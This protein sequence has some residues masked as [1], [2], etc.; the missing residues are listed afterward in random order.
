MNTDIPSVERTTLSTEISIARKKI[1]E[2]KTIVLGGDESSPNK[3]KGRNQI[4]SLIQDVNDINDNLQQI[5][6][7]LH[8]LK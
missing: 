3:E 2:I 8:G 7:A 5:L 6:E 1:G 4:D